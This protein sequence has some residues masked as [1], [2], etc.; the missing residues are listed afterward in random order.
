M[1]TR[2]SGHRGTAR[3]CGPWPPPTQDPIA[4]HALRGGIGI[5]CEACGQRSPFPTA[6]ER[7]LP[8]KAAVPAVLRMAGGS[9]FSPSPLPAPPS[10]EREPGDLTSP[11][12]PRK[13]RTGGLRRAASAAGR[14]H[15]PLTPARSPSGG[16]GAGGPNVPRTPSK[17][18]G[19]QTEPD[20][21]AARAPRHVWRAAHLPLTPARSPSGGAG[22]GGPNVPRTPSKAADGRAAAAGRVRRARAPWRVWRLVARNTQLEKN[23]WS[24][25]RRDPRLG[26]CTWRLVARDPRLGSCSWRLAARCSPLGKKIRRQLAQL[27]PHPQEGGE[28]NAAPGR[29]RPP[30]ARS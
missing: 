27:L 7:G 21:S 17:A 15:L 5:D 18:A 23:A 2:A 13:R 29:T 28:G 9:S 6:S 24:L 12:P 16:A 26:S 25:V 10:G 30:P 1:E 4:P 11:A 3:P 22:A 20:A 14:G 19:R 8:A